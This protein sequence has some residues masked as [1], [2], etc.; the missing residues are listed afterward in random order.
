MVLTDILIFTNEEYVENL[1]DAKKRCSEKYS[2]YTTHIHWNKYNNVL[3]VSL[4]AH[5]LTSW[6][7]TLVFLRA[8]TWTQVQRAEEVLL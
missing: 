7:E 4:F 5:G 2:D 8:C 3:F 1:Y 6:E